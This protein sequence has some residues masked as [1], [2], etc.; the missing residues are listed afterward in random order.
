MYFF[1]Y[2]VI[3]LYYIITTVGGKNAVSY[4]EITGLKFLQHSSMSSLIF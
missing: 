4:L 1:A 2:V 3:I